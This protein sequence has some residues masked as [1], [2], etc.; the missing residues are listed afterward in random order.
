MRAAIAVIAVI[1]VIA[2]ISLAGC[3]KGPEGPAGAQGQPGP[4]GPP[5]KQGE[6]GVAGPVGPP[7]P[8]GSTGLHAVRH[9]TCAPSNNCDLT[10][11]PGERLVSVTCPGG[12]IEISRNAGVESAACS[13]TPGPAFALCMKEP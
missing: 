8:M 13:D 11:G 1:A 7:G 9:A 3:S 6:Q 5:G 4:Q 10:C 12:K 2:A